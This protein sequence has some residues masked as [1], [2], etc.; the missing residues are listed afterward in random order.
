MMSFLF[1]AD[2]QLF[3]QMASDAGT[4]TFDTGIHTPLDVSQ[5]LSLGGA[6][7]QKVVARAQSDGAN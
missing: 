3:V 1:H 7:G 2:S 5:G 6:V 4:S